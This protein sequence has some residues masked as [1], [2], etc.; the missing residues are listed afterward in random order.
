M[1]KKVLSCLTAL[2]LVLAFAFSASADVILPPDQ[3]II[4]D[5]PD[6]SDAAQTQGYVETFSGPIE[7]VDITDELLSVIAEENSAPAESAE[8]A[9]SAE[10]ETMIL[11]GAAE[12]P[13]AYTLP[14]VDVGQV[15]SA[16]KSLVK[17]ILVCLVI[18]AVI[19]LI[20]V[21]SV[22]SSY[23]PVHRKRDAA[24][25]LVDGS[26]N[27]TASDDTFLRTERSERKIQTKDSDE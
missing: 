8:T 4:T 23:K 19:A 11:Y 13:E 16:Q 15:E 20:V 26:L 6:G 21:L 14:D 12:V 24:E 3:G 2:A 17:P 1:K 18:G 5:S 10:E 9:E 7:R 25:Y 22:K 27:V